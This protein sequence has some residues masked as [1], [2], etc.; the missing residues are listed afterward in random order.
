MEINL[1]KA[2]CSVNAMSYIKKIFAIVFIVAFLASMPLAFAESKSD[3]VQVVYVL[4]DDNNY[5]KPGG[6]PG[7]A[8]PSADY[9]I[10]FK[11]YKTDIP[12]PLTVYTANPEG[13]SASFVYN[14]IVTSAAT[15]DSETSA[16]LVGT[17]SQVDDESGV[18]GRDYQNSIMFGTYSDNRAIAV[19]YAWIDRATKQLIEFDILF[20][21]YY[22]WGNADPTKMD[23]Q[24]IATHELGHGFNLADIY[25]QSKS[26]LTMFG[27]SG[28]GDTAKRTL[29]LGDIAGIHAVFGT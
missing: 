2:K 12:A 18:L 26:A 5:A 20:N 22:D 29:E 28:E 24:N 14:T 10:W 25:D 3:A 8:K 4:K 7:G 17:I 19:T 13:L 21:V 16:D 1:I 6:T 15:W 11:G 23:L 9:K 27:Y